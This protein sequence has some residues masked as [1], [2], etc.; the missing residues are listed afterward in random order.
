VVLALVDEI[1]DMTLSDIAAHL[2]RTSH[3]DPGEECGLDILGAP[4]RSLALLG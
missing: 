4:N 2:A 1:P 3:H